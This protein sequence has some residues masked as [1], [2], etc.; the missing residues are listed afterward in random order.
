MRLRIHRLGSQRRFRLDRGP[1]L[2]FQPLI[3]FDQIV[4]RLRRRTGVSAGRRDERALRS[5]NV[6]KLKINPF[7]S[8]CNQ[9]KL[10][11]FTFD[12]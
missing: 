8:Q 1:T 11:Q 10:S 6:P 4:P 2:L 5:G 9:S 3:A 7:P 12:P